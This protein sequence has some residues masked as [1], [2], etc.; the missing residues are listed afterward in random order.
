M[1]TTDTTGL[2]NFTTTVPLA[3]ACS[4]TLDIIKGGVLGKLTVAIFDK[5]NKLLLTG[6]MDKPSALTTQNGGHV[7]WV[8]STPQM[9]SAL[10]WGVMAFAP[11]ANASDYTAVVRV[12]GAQGVE[13]ARSTFS[14]KL[15]S[16]N[17]PV[18]QD[19]VFVTAS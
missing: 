18:V 19:G 17:D 16:F 14:G 7:G 10:C 11:V 6:G 8:F 3:G 5:D 4:I 2:L 12:I 15:T 9:A 13:V 1:P